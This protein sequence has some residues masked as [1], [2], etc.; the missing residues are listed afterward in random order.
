[1]SDAEKYTH[2]HHDSVLRSHRW[3]D[4]SNSAGYLAPHLRPE[5]SVLDVGC[6]PGSITVDLAARV[7]HVVGIDLDEGVL[8]EARTRA[9]DIDNV[10][11]RAA[12]VYHLPFADHSF[13][14]VHAH[15]TLQHLADPVTAL[16]ELRRV[17]RPGG[18]VAARDADYAA[19]TW[20]PSARELDEWLALYQRCARANGGEPDAGRRLLAWAHAAGFTQIT[21]TASVW[22]HASED[23]RRWWGEMWRD[24]IIQSAMADQARE[25]GWASHADLERLSAGWQRF[26]DHPDGWFTVLHGEILCTA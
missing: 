2:G 7:A 19:M 5:D 22:C 21:P 23:E 4:V 11:F 3:R 9:A 15:Q 12:D 20:Y 1:M 13:D 16:V 8:D 25:Q 14:V 24:R 26:A 10:E 6:G 18:L 17:T